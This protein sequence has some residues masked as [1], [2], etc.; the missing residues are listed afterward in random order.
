[1]GQISPLVWDEDAQAG[2]ASAYGPFLP[3]PAR[4]FTEGAFGPFS[5]ILPVPVDT[6]APGM[7]LADPRRFQYPTGYN[8]PTPPGLDGFRLASFETLETLSRLHSVTRTCIE[9]RKMMIAGLEWDIVPTREAAKA[10]SGSHAAMKDFGERRAKAVRFYERPDPDFDDWASFQSALLEQMF[11]YDAMSLLLKPKR[12]RGLKRGILGSD[13][14]SLSLIDGAT[15]RPLLSLSGGRP[16]PPRPR[17]SS[18]FSACPGRTSS[19]CGRGRT[20]RT[21]A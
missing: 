20:S 18:S 13:L 9:R 12:G 17:S 4:T 2:Y 6:P 1:M 5:P 16:R 15:I 10:Y 7:E 8:L 21:P 3:Q 19:R 11:V 14:D